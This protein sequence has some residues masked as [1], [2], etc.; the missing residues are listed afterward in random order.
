MPN[1]DLQGKI[2]L[3]LSQVKSYSTI[4]KI[5]EG[6]L[7][8][9]RLMKVMGKGDDATTEEV[10]TVVN[11][12]VI[13]LKIL[14]GQGGHASDEFV[15]ILSGEVNDVNAAVIVHTLIELGRLDAVLTIA[16]SLKRDNIDVRRAVWS[17]V[18]EK[19]RREP[20]R[21]SDDD[22]EAIEA[23]RT[24]EIPRI[25]RLRRSGEDSPR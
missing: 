3:I 16:A 11:E 8:S 22:L 23:R 14:Y 5:K 17:A 4:Y 13:L 21:F 12:Q 25:P 19:L 1:D 24:V 7:L 6:E 9:K 18:G 15:K 10:S 20:H 2:R